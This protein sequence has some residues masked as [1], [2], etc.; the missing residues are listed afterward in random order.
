[1]KDFFQNK[2]G[3]TLGFIVFYIVNLIVGPIKLLVAALATPWF[4]LDFTWG[5]VG[6]GM[7]LTGGTIMILLGGEVK[8]KWGKYARV[9]AP[10]YLDGW[11]GAFSLGP[12]LTGVKDAPWDHEY[13]HT[14]QNR[15]LGPFYP[16]VIAVPSLFSASISARTHRSFYTESWA[17]KWSAW[18]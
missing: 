5:V 4:W 15:I 17:D 11:G 2:L 10:D 8:P 7:G 13:G 16:F 1:M 3:K 18:I 12:I 6:T 9:I 14:W